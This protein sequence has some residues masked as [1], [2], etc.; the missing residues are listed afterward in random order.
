MQDGKEKGGKPMNATNPIEERHSG[1]ARGE[2][3]FAGGEWFGKKTAWTLAVL[4]LGAVVL[5]IA[6]LV[7]PTMRDR[8]HEPWRESFAAADSARESGDRYRA[9][10]MYI[11]SA[12]IASSTDDWRADLAIACGLQKLGKTEGPS[13]YGFNVLVSAMGAA[14]RRKSAEGMQA[15]AAAFASLGDAYASFALSRVGD[16]WPGAES[17]GQPVVKPRTFTVAQP[18]C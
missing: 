10:E 3:P 16:D 4:T 6:W 14:E 17:G 2:A 7:P 13:L 11:H 15:V 8:P 12:R 1:Y 9:L 18:G 5:L